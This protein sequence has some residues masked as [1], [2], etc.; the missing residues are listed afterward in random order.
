MAANDALKMLQAG[1]KPRPAHVA[2][3]PEPPA[4]PPESVVPVAETPKP[5]AYVK[6]SVF[7]TPDQ[8][9]WL[10]EVVARAKLDGIDG[11]SASDVV[12]LALARLRAETG[13]TLVLTDELVRQAYDE[14]ER[15][16]GRKNRGLPARPA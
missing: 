8:R 13:E 7:V 1:R 9:T 6:T 2:V 3:V 14:V 12:R 16:P 10:N 4:A 5:L 11:I 15:F